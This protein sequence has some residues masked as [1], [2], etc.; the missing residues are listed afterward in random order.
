MP[1]SLATVK[2]LL[3]Q[4][5]LDTLLVYPG[6]SGA[7]LFARTPIKLEMD[8]PKSRDGFVVSDLNRDGRDELILHVERD[9]SSVLS[10]IEF[11]D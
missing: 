10:V 4:K 5:G 7:K 9:E 8:L 1:T 11:S 2:D 3:V 6:Q